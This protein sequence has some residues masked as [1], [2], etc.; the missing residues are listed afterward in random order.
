MVDQY[1][2][3]VEEC[4]EKL[5]DEESVNKMALKLRDLLKDGETKT[6][7]HM[8][9][10]M[11]EA[12]RKKFNVEMEEHPKKKKKTRVDLIVSLGDVNMMMELKFYNELS[13]AGFKQILNN[14]YYKW[15][16][17][18]KVKKCFIMGILFKEW[19]RNCDVSISY[20]EFVLEDIDNML[21]KMKTIDV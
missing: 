10:F 9:S 21:G 1:I 20:S 19:K 3:A 11:F 6:H 14:K 8:Q 17:D 12:L 7:N 15:F 4:F 16:E 13:E 5:C 18:K 2:K